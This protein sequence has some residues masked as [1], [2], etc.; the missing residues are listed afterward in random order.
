[1]CIHKY[2]YSIG[3]THTNASISSI[4]S[5]D[6]T[7]DGRNAAMVLE[8]KRK[9]RKKLIEDNPFVNHKTSWPF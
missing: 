1:M 7:T 6:G 2:A 4:I 8:I 9:E 5:Q 3:H